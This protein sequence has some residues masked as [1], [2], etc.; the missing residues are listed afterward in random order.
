MLLMDLFF[1]GM[2]TTVTTAKW[3]ILM[4]M[5]HPEVQKKAQAELDQ[6]P[7]GILL[8]DKPKLTYVNAMINVIM[9]TLTSFNYLIVGNSTNS[10][11][12][13]YKFA[14]SCS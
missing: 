10:Q 12:P 6:L 8:T 14:Q 1:A 13:A 2:E 5:T 11:Y 3:G 9:S 7:E 4:L